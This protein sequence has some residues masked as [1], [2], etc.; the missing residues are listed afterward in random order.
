MMTMTSCHDK[1]IH[2]TAWQW[3]YWTNRRIPVS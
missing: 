2:L 1:L 3:H